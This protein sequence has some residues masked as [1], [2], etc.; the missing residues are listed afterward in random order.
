VSQADLLLV[1][2]CVLGGFSILLWFLGLRADRVDADIAAL[3][4][5]QGAL[6]EEAS[7]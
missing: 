5:V 6:V 4:K 1:A 2:V 3:R 7:R